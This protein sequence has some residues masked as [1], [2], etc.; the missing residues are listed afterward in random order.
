M[1]TPS[2]KRLQIKADVITLIC[3]FFF[4]VLIAML[5]N[6]HTGGAALGLIFPML[7]VGLLHLILGPVAISAAIATKRFGRNSWIFGYYLFFLVAVLSYAGIFR[8]ISHYV[9]ESWERSER[10]SEY[11]LYVTIEQGDTQEVAR[12]LEAGAD[13]AYCF[14]SVR[15]Y[16]MRSPLQYAIELGEWEHERRLLGAGDPPR[17]RSG[18]VAALL[19]YGADP[20][21]VCIDQNGNAGLPPVLLALKK[22]DEQILDLL[23]H[24]GA[25]LD[26]LPNY[27]ALVM[28]IAGERYRLPVDS[29][30]IKNQRKRLDAGNVYTVITRLLEAGADVNALQNGTPLQ[31][32]VAVGDVRLVEQFLAAGADPDGIVPEGKA[33]LPP[34]L[35]ALKRPDEQ[36]LNL[37]LK[38]GADPEPLPNHSALVVAI[39][40]KHYQRLPDNSYQ[41]NKRRDRLDAGKVYPIITRLLEAG[42][43][44]NGLQDGATPLHWAVA[45]GDVRLVDKLLAAGADPDIKDRSGRSSLDWSID[46]DVPEIK[47]RL[48]SHKHLPPS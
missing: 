25:D 29:F 47:K 16:R 8:S 18:I 26:P 41:V 28:A 7:F 34:I 27:S 3:V 13:P 4:I 40:G 33:G 43:D 30:E 36:I 24:S 23:L 10:A 6:P 22:P 5:S 11:A 17:P 35:L 1:N 46:T 39:A 12:L 2:Q 45:V 21:G 9:S 42:A 38:S 37:L 48:E 31:W 19:D 32:A 14:Q 15:D 20:N 44:V